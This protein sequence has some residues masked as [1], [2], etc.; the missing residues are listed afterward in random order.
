MF[1][2]VIFGGLFAIILNVADWNYNVLKWYGFVRV[3]TSS[4]KWV[5]FKHIPLV[6]WAQAQVECSLCDPQT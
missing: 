3:S 2:L 6:G 5:R 4:V 1:N